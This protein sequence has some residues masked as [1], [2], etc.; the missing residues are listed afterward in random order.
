VL[1]LSVGAMGYALLESG[2]SPFIVHASWEQGC[3][4]TSNNCSGQLI[5]YSSGFPPGWGTCGYV[6]GQDENGNQM[7]I[8]AGGYCNTRTNPSWE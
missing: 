5:C 6:A 1:T 2:L 3:C 4:I 8:E 7:M